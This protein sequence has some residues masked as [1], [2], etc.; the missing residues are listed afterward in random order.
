MVDNL[1]TSSTQSTSGKFC[2]RL[3]TSPTPFW[4]SLYYDDKYSETPETQISS[5]SDVQ[6][7][8]WVCYRL[9]VYDVD[10][11]TFVLQTQLKETKFPPT[12]SWNEIIWRSPWFSL[13]WNTLLKVLG[14][15]P[16]ALVPA[17]SL[18]A[19]WILLLANC[20]L[21][22]TIRCLA[23]HQLT[24]AARPKTSLCH[25]TLAVFA[26]ESPETATLLESDVRPLLNQ[27]EITGI[28]T[29]FMV[30]YVPR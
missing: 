23:A 21:I 10:S 16:F 13:F 4:N 8:F 6:L 22:V 15:F 29:H 20:H 12:N 27:R 25:P 1:A 19:K 28:D 3:V 18:D 5:K 14:S 26:I 2:S 7:I 9:Q 30:P 11:I 24:A 17:C